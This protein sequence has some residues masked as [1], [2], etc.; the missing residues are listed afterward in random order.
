MEPER[1]YDIV[2]YK[3]AGIPWPC[4][5]LLSEQAAHGYYMAEA[6]PRSGPLFVGMN[7]IPPGPAEPLTTPGHT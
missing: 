7:W 6:R 5:S 3:Q 2:C 4:C 1:R